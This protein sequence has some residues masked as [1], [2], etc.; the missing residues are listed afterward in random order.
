MAVRLFGPKR[1]VDRL[2][3]ALTALISVFAVSG[4]GAGAASASTC[5]S[6]N[7]VTL[8]DVVSVDFTQALDHAARWDRSELLH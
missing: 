2:S 3:A 8:M 7:A 1:R 6:P 4:I 5:K